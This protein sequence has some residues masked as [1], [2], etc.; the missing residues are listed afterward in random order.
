[1]IAGV[2][3]AIAAVSMFAFA[4]LATAELKPNEIAQSLDEGAQAVTNLGE[5]VT[6]TSV[7]TDASAPA[8]TTAADGPVAAAPRRRRCPP[9]RR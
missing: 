2:A 3:A 6:S 8:D 7:A 5:T 4:N 9:V 1:M